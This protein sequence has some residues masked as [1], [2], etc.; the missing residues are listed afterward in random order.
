MEE[1]MNKICK[2]YKDQEEIMKQKYQNIR[3]H[4]YS[5]LDN[6]CDYEQYGT[7]SIEE[8]EEQLD[9]QIK[10]N[11]VIEE[12]QAKLEERLKLLK[13][14]YNKLLTQNNELVQEESQLN[15]IKK[16]NNE[17]SATISSKTIKLP[18]PVQYIESLQVLEVEKEQKDDDCFSFPNVS[19][20]VIN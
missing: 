17:L 1:F 5:N 16:M 8:L 9:Q 14:E 7:L 15:K 11:D 3:Y 19:R 13:E 20:I 10:T 2:Q 12:E 18:E 4:N 6:D